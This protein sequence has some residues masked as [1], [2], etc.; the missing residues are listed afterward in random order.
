VVNSQ[1]IPIGPAPTNDFT[2]RREA[3]GRALTRLT[4]MGRPALVIHPRCKVLRKAMN[5]GY[6]FRR[7]AASGQERFRDVPD[8]NS[9]SHVAEALQYMAVGEGEDSVALESSTERRKVSQ[10]FKVKTAGARRR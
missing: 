6:C 2:L 9:F 7:V 1:G 4:M 8:K 10:R 3:V 5:G